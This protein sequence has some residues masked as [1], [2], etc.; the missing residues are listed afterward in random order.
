MHANTSHQVP[1]KLGV[2]SRVTHF[3]NIFYGC[4][5]TRIQMIPRKKIF[6]C[7]LNI[8]DFQRYIIL[9]TEKRW[10]IESN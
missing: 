6:I 10:G 3:S 1:H 4:K 8:C 7:Q 9:S 5:G 2:K